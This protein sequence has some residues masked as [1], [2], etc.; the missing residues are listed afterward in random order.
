M[1][2]PPQCRPQHHGDLA[3]RRVGRFVVH[4]GRAA[5]GRDENVVVLP[6][7]LLE[8]RLSHFISLSIFINIIFDWFLGVYDN[9]PAWRERGVMQVEVVGLEIDAAKHRGHGEGV[10]VGQVAGRRAHLQVFYLVCQ[11]VVRQEDDYY[12]RTSK[13]R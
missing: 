7:G 4:A 10:A 3:R 9:G 6:R 12:S 13:A 1:K 8:A 2:V 11:S 5:Y